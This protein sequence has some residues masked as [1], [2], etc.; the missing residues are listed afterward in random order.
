MKLNGLKDSRNFGIRQFWNKVEN[1]KPLFES[2]ESFLTSH[3]VIH[4]IWIICSMKIVAISDTHGLHNSLQIPDG[5]ILIHAG[6]L[7]HT[8]QIKSGLFL[9]ISP[10]KRYNLH[11][12][13]ASSIGRAIDS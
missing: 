8:Q 2:V 11:S 10:L 1:P 9:D 12:R 3:K 4:N 7:P 5:D 6:D 13:P